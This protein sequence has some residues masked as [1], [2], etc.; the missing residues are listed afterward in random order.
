MNDTQSVVNLS[1]VWSVRS[2]HTAASVPSVNKDSHEF[3][4]IAYFKQNA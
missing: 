2:S 1:S 4:D 3:I